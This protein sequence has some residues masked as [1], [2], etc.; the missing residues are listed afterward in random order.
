MQSSTV[1]TA[2]RRPIPV[3]VKAARIIALGTIIAAIVGGII[4]YIIQSQH[5]PT[6]TK[7]TAAT[8]APASDPNPTSGKSPSLW[9]QQWYLK[10]TKIEVVPDQNV[11]SPLKATD[12]PYRLNAEVNGSIVFSW[13]TLSAYCIGP[14]TGPIVENIALPVNQSSYTVS[15][16]TYSARA[17]LSSLNAYLATSNGFTRQAAAFTATNPIFGQPSTPVIINSA[18]LPFHSNAQAPLPLF[19]QQDPNQSDIGHVTIYYEITTNT[20]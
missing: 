13:P 6:V 17:L 8:T 20:P 19:S 12:I 14:D 3:G 16:Y 15:F 1:Q 9:N 2:Q 7:T 10:V 18:N 11:S 4:T 5:S